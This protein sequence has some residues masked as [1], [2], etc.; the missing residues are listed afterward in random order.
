MTD[1]KSGQEA[2]APLPLTRAIVWGVLLG[3]LAVYLFI[4]I[5]SWSPGDP[6]FSDYPS[7][8]QIANKGGR[9]GA[10]VS[11]FLRMSLGFASYGLPLLSAAAAWTFFRRRPITRRWKRFVSAAFFLAAWACLA[12]LVAGGKAE[13]FTGPGG[14]CGRVLNRFI[15]GPC[16]WGAWI[17]V[18]AI[19]AGSL[20]FLTEPAC[21]RFFAWVKAQWLR[22]RAKWQE[23]KFYRQRLKHVLD[24]GPEREASVLIRDRSAAPPPPFDL[25]PITMTTTT[26]PAAASA[27]P[28]AI[29]TQAKPSAPTEPL[30][31]PKSAG[32]PAPVKSDGAERSD[33]SDESDRPEKTAPPE[34]TGV[35]DL[36]ETTRLEEEDLD[37]G[38]DEEDDSED[39]TIP[40]QA[41][42][43][44]VGDEST[45]EKEKPPDDAPQPEA[46][47]AGGPAAKPAPPPQPP[48]KRKPAGSDKPYVM[49]GFDLLDP[50]PK[51]GEVDEARLE[52]TRRLLENSLREF[53]VDA[54]VL[55]NPDRGPVIT[56][57]ELKLAPG[58]KIS[59]IVGLADDIARSLSATS[60]RIVAPIPGKSTVGIEVPNSRRHTVT[61]RSVLEESES[62]WRNYGIPLIIGRDASGVPLVDDLTKMPHLLI[63]GATGTG[64]SV[65]INSLIV[66]LLLTQSPRNLKLLLIDPKMVEFAA[67]KEVP[68]LLAPVVVDMKKATSILEWATQKMDQRYE[69]LSAVGARNIVSFNAL[70]EK[71]VR[72]RLGADPDSD[73]EDF[74]THLPYIVIIIDELADLMMVANKEV[75]NSI[76][77]LAQKSRAVGIHLVIATQ[78]PSVDVITGLIKSNLPSRMALQVASKV[79][80]RTILDRNGAEKLLGMGDMLFLP[81]GSSKLIRAQG[82]YVSDA[83]IRRVVNYLKEQAK[84]EFDEELVR[85]RAAN[86]IPPWQRDELFVEAAK[87]IAETQRGSVSLLQR[88]FQIGYSRAARLVDMMAEI[89]WLGDYKGSQARE[90][91]V[92]VKDIEDY[93]QQE[94]PGE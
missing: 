47:A 17:A 31:L 91:L 1:E 82:A 67:F 32:A 48:R 4:A 58:V 64:K 94:S 5:V 20:I 69:S 81:P 18:L 27:A 42:S 41:V 43:A 75:E 74:P 10:A 13:T 63:A 86:E 16:G 38:P 25:T 59:R 9:V 22:A 44:Q 87:A 71:G 54:Q 40:E 80:S 24:A 23:R 11:G 33:K 73:L 92:S 57:Y 36:I 56:M 83:E 50:G 19:F 65:S 35:E 77:R 70:G 72:E 62:K 46:V 79:D 53:N 85:Q 45:E 29:E 55:P 30:L 51:M 34:H 49:P 6:P 8:A 89:G 39:A 37:L 12:D 93:V 3:G 15:F 88:K 66:S 61:L 60:V 14:L 28:A 26:Q 7:N 84:P 2:V 76:I 78:R 90:V 68:H 21:F 52:E